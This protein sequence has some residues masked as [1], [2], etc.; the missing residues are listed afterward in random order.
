MFWQFFFI[1]LQ[2]NRPIPSLCIPLEKWM[3]FRPRREIPI[4]FISSHAFQYVPWMQTLYSAAFFTV[5]S[6]S[7]FSLSRFCELRTFQSCLLCIYLIL[8][9]YIL[10]INDIILYII[11]IIIIYYPSFSSLANSKSLCPFVFSKSEQIL[12]KK[13]F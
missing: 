11:Y 12:T 7:R 6:S 2:Y 9:F 5:I 3:W 4:C 1:F 13:A 10:Y 8:L